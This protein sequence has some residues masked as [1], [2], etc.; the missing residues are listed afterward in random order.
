MIPSILIT[1]DDDVAPSLVEE[2]W[3]AIY[4]EVPRVAL[5]IRY[6]SLTGKDLSA[7]CERLQGRT[8]FAT[9]LVSR[10][11]DV[12]HALDLSGAHLPANG[13]PTSSARSYLGMKAMILRAA[14][15]EAELEQA[16]GA[17]G[18]LISPVFTP[19]SHASER[20]PLGLEGLRALA[21]MSPVPVMAMGGITPDNVKDVMACGAGGVAVSGHVWRAPDPVAA[22]VALWKAMSAE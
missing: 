12:V 8:P 19:I 2:T 21:A 18:V 15:D 13:V 11:L 1:T 9:L 22:T 16:R 6:R 7:L 5:S 3:P 20:N 10:R 4:R 17:D 14:H